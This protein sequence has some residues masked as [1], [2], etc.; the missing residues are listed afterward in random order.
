MNETMVMELGRDTLT[1]MLLLM[2]PP[3]VVAL[4]VGVA[5]SILQAATQVQEMTL[6]L[7]PKILAIF[8]ALLAFSPWMTQIFLAFAQRLFAGFPDLIR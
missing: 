8:A 3:L 4:V 1:T 2:A 5:I 7:V 6:S